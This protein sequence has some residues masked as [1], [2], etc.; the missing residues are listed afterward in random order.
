[1]SKVKEYSCKLLIF[2]V[3]DE[4]K[5]DD[6]KFVIY[7]FGIDEKRNVYTLRIA[8]FKPFIYIKVEGDKLT[9]DKNTLNSFKEALINDL[10]E[11]DV[12]IDDKQIEKLSHHRHQKLY[13]FDCNKE[14]DLSLIHI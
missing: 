4:G 9:W 5:Y 3:K 2:D 1:M 10:A 6:R 13:G 12:I 8:D 7:A 14:Y 11:R